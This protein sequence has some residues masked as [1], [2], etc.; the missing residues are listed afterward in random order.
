MTKYVVAGGSDT[1]RPTVNRRHALEI[2]SS[3]SYLT[4][5]LAYLRSAGILKASTPDALFDGLRACPGFP[6]YVMS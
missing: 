3:H 1:E 6:G 5:G 2:I 4:S